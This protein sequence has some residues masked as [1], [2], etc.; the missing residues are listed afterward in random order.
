MMT[1]AKLLETVRDG[2]EEASKATARGLC[3]EQR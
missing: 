1:V 3:R 2:G